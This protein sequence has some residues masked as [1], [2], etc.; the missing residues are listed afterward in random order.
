MI[1]PIYSLR[2]AA[3]LIP[4]SSTN[5]LYQFLCKHKSQFTAR[6]RIG[7][8]PERI[9]SESEILKIRSMVI[10]TDS[11]W[12]RRPSPGRPKGVKNGMGRQ[13]IPRVRSSPLTFSEIFQTG[14]SP[15]EEVVGT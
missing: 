12:S 15:G 13:A 2:V 5:A 9:L 7:R 3:E 1:E 14:A 8:P 6:Y 11:W 10:S 4:M